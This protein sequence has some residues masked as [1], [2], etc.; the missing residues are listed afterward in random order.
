VRLFASLGLEF[1]C[2]QSFAKN[3]G[4]YGES[5]T[6]LVSLPLSL[7]TLFHDP[8]LFFFHSGERIG[9]LVVVCQTASIAENVRSQMKRLIRG[10]I[11]NPPAY[12]ARIAA[13]ILNNP[14]L[15]A[16]W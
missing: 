8:F 9:N 13:K 14:Q 1:F 15:F 16:E 2:A 7:W 11:S 6:L 10:M 5:E 4:L 12:G 3:M